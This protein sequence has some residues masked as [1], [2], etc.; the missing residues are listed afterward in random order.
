ML[1]KS[2][3]SEGHL[4]SGFLS[5]CPSSPRHF[6]TRARHPQE[7]GHSHP[8]KGI[9]FLNRAIS[10]KEERATSLAVDSLCLVTPLQPGSGESRLPRKPDL[11]LRRHQEAGTGGP[12]HVGHKC[13]LH[14][15][16]GPAC[17]PLPLPWASRASSSWGTREPIVHQV[18]CGFLIVAIILRHSCFILNPCPFQ[19]VKPFIWPFAV[20]QGHHLVISHLALGP[21]LAGARRS[22]Q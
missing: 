3:H 2:S 21:I 1:W 17:W 18:H 16:P 9:F 5:L 12:R 7:Q 22:T 15:W 14:S 19:L 11:R 8:H 20:G 6:C 10:E 13:S 4:G